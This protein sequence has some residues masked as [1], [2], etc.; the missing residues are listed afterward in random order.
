MTQPLVGMSL[1]EVLGPNISVSSHMEGQDSFSGPV[2]SAA[3]PDADVQQRVGVAQTAPS[4]GLNSLV[5]GAQ[6][7]PVSPGGR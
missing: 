7:K 2:V 5:L 1:T 4:A 3:N 6:N